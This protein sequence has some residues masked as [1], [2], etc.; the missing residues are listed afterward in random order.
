LG[1]SNDIDGEFT[2]LVSLTQIMKTAILLPNW[3]G[4]ACMATPTLR[5]LRL[6][7][8]EISELCVVG[9]YAPVN[10]LE[11]LPWVDS[12]IVYKP[13][14]ND[15][16]VLSRRGMIAE[17]KKRSFDSIIL[18]PNSLSAG[19]I[20]YF[21]GTPQRIGYANDGRSWLLTQPI[22]TRRDG[23][24]L[25]K[26][27]ALD[28]Y[29]NIASQLGCDISDRRMELT[30]AES[31]RDHGRRMFNELGLDW[32]KPTVVFNT[33]SAT[34][35]SRLWPIG[36]AS[37]AAATLAKQHDIQ[38]L[39]HSGPA[40]RERA[41]AIEFG[42]ANPM[43]KSMGRIESIPISLSKAVL[44][45]A[46]VVLS[47]DSG[48]RHM[49][50]AL[51]KKVVSLFGSTAPELTQTYNLPETILRKEMA[52]SPCG[53]PKCP[54]VHNNCMHGIHYSQVVNAILLNMESHRSEPGPTWQSAGS[55]RA[56]ASPSKAA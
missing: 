18:L 48:P 13:K 28:Y 19:L 1:K 21:S 7:L 52:C 23:T 6:G 33:A 11:G 49:A 41:N 43:V 35:S 53:K 14:S 25:R 4:D 50:V 2:L 55:Q 31:D 15:A 10:V 42:A 17:L 47:T 46:D 51:N 39:I 37:R 8:P 32:D 20:G 5:A 27:S 38:V 29:L 16:R 3:V 54:L 9:R 12:S 36:H 26:G 22:S 24:D 45:Q 34:G 40:D 44:E 56:F 30:V